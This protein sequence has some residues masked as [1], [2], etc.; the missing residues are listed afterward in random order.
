MDDLIIVAP[1]VVGA[2]ADN[3]GGT[4][5]GVGVV[6]S[7]VACLNPKTLNTKTLH[8]KPKDVN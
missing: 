3:I 4:G 1:G 2:G 8:P 5:V 7:A 6:V